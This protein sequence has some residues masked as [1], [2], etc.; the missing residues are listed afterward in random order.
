MLQSLSGRDRSFGAGVWGAEPS[1]VQAARRRRSQADGA[2]APHT[3]AG[4]GQSQQA[5]EGEMSLK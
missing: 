5:E 1:A 4:S 3:A 2:A